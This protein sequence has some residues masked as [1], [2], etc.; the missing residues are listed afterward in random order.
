M[1]APEAAAAVSGKQLVVSPALVLY[2]T[3]CQGL[4]TQHLQPQQQREQQQYELVC[5]QT[6]HLHGMK[7]VVGA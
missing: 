4:E 6:Q 5:G 1:T 3:G 2:K 7:Q